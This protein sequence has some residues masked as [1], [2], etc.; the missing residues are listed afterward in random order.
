MAYGKAGGECLIVETRKGRYFGLDPVGRDFWE[1]IL[2]GRRLGLAR[3]RLLARHRVG[4]RRLTRDLL[5][6]A[7]LLVRH[8]LLRRA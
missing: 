7:R 4:S 3:A 8:G 5:A 6:F 1:E 2:R